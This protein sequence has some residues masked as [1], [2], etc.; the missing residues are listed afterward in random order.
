[1]VLAYNNSLILILTCRVY[2]GK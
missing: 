2:V 1:M